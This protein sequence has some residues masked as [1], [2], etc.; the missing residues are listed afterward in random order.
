MT[1]I[2][3]INHAALLPIDASMLDIAQAK[4]DLRQIENVI[5]REETVNNWRD[6]MAHLEF[7]E[8]EQEETAAAGHLVRI[9]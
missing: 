7:I 9:V 1:A 3:I 5:T 2:E 4:A 8:T 6:A